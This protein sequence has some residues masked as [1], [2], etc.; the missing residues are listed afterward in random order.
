MLLVCE[1]FA[2]NPEFRVGNFVVN[3]KR[4]ISHAKSKCHGIW[5]PTVMHGVF[6][7]IRNVEWLGHPQGFVDVVLGARRQQAKR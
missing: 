2:E 3:L 6:C 1:K 4:E 5:P 7:L